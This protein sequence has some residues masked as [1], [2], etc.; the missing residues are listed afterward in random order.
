MT[1]TNGYATLD[2]FK[3]RHYASSADTTDDTDIEFIIQTASRDIDNYMGRRF[4]STSADETRTYQA[5]SPCRV[6]TDDLL[7]ITSLKTDEDG[8]RTYELTWATTDY[9]LLPE[10]AV[11]DSKPYTYIEIAPQGNYSFPMH[12]KAVQIV[13]TFGYCVTGSEP[14]IINQACLI[15][16][17]RIY[18]RKNAPFGVTA[19]NEF[20]Q[21]T[22]MG[23]LDPD[24][25]QMLNPL[26]RKFY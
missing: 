13:G 2:E 18:Q 21:Q 5:S 10:N 20:G 1:I 8:D 25:E 17:N 23:K 24:V 15:Q 16:A 14:D 26:R 11:V 4:Y 9:D 7:T 19:P 3:A 6:F 22:V 12:R